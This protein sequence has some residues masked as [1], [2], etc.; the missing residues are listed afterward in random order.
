MQPQDLF[1]NMSCGCT[2]LWS[3]EAIVAGVISISALLTLKCQNK[4][5]T[6]LGV[7]SLSLTPK[8]VSL[9]DVSDTRNM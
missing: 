2:A 1:C 9:M 3:T 5:V 4:M 8:P 7:F 6:Y